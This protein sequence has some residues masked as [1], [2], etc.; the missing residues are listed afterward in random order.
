MLIGL[1]AKCGTSAFLSI[2]QQQF[3]DIT[4]DGREEEG[5][6]FKSVT[7]SFLGEWLRVFVAEKWSRANTIM[8]LDKDWVGGSPKEHGVPPIWA[9]FMQARVS[10]VGDT[11]TSV[12]QTIV[13]QAMFFLLLCIIIPC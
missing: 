9:P 12:A 5:C 8:D 3:L 2:S 6:F 7:H 10:Q 1:Q 13:N 4:G 11:S